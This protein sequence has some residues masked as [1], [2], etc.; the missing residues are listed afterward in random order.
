MHVTIPPSPRYC[1]SLLTPCHVRWHTHKNTPLLAPVSGRLSYVTFPGLKVLAQRRS[2]QPYTGQPIRTYLVEE[3]GPG[4]LGNV[5]SLIHR[6]SP[7]HQKLSNLLPFFFF[8]FF[9]SFLS[10]S[11]AK[12]AASG[13]LL[14]SASQNDFAYFQA[15]LF[16]AL[17]SNISVRPGGQTIQILDQYMV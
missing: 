15:V 11:S 5:V 13:T 17:P 16:N 14:R 3:E 12:L 4:R 9:P 1:I 8:F 10:F 6:C 2:Y 7:K